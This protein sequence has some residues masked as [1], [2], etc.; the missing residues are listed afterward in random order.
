MNVD[1]SNLHA[2]LV[3]VKSKLKGSG[4]WLNLGLTE[5]SYVL[6]ATHNIDVDNI[7]VYDSNKKLL[8]SEFVCSLEEFD[9]SIIKINIACNNN[10]ELCID[11]KIKMNHD[12]K[13]WILGYPKSLVK[14][15]IHKSI[16]HQGTILNVEEKMFFRIDENLPTYSDKDNIEGFSGGPIFEVTNDTIYLK[17][18]ITDS[19]DESFSYQRILGTKLIKVI[20]S[21]PSLI[22]EEIKCKN[23]ID[24]IV[25]KSCEVLDEKIIQYILDG[26]FLEK[27]KYL[28]LEELQKCKYFY[29][30]DDQPKNTQHLSLLRNL[31]SLKSYIHTRIIS[32]IMDEELSDVLLNPTNFESER[33]FTIHVTDFKEKHKLVANLIRQENSFEYSNS[34][35]LIIYSNDNNDLK[36]LT[37]KRVSRVISNYAEGRIPELYDTS[38]SVLEKGRLRNFL[39]PIKKSRMKFSVIN[40][41]FLVEMI[42]SH[43]EN[44]FY[45]EEYDKSLIKNEIIEVVKK[46]E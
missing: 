34:I 23:T 4:V 33:I 46:Y 3:Q 25:E 41:K 22:K 18:I 30:P 45:D 6:T 32:M 40:I 29:L 9:V 13:C 44:E 1:L 15:S 26:D 28:D 12:S 21:L 36:Y 7:E 5:H 10:I 16:E 11:E 37:K 39:E 24:E 14:T 17:G 42:V 38:A 19:F 2:A 27:L 8:D 35:V 31:E 20:D 43:I